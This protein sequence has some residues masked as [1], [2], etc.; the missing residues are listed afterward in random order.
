MRMLSPLLLASA[1]ALPL[2]QIAHAEAAQITV[3]GEAT[4]A[5]APDLAVIDLGVT[6]T[7]TTAAEA[8][9]SNA[10]AMTSVMDRLRSAG[11]A[12]AD[13]QTATLQLNPN[14]VSASSDVAPTIN[15]Y[16][17]SNQVSVRLRALDTLGTVLD[18][19]VS[20]GANTLNGVSFDLANKRPA[21][22]QARSAAV[23]DAI[24]RATLL[25]E[26]AGVKLGKIA[27]I[28]EG[29]MAAGPT[30]MFRMEASA[31]PVAAGELDITQSVTVTFDIAE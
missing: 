5:V 15:G 6:S 31:T 7:G 18:A 1:L 13:L 25:S 22:D 10:T 24:A 23:K 20:D 12:E 29:G 21:Q 26:A 30:P 11:V 27:S 14:W 28:S 9:A 8:M 4:V 19:A 3:T 16:T 2:A 17:A